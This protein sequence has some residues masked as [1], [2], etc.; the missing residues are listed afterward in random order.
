MYVGRKWTEN[1]ELHLGAS[2]GKHVTDM[3]GETLLLPLVPIAYSAA[4]TCNKVTDNIWWIIIS[5][6]FYNLPS[7]HWVPQHPGQLHKLGPINKAETTGILGLLR[8]AQHYAIHQHSR[9][10]VVSWERWQS[11]VQCTDLQRHQGTLPW[12][13]FQIHSH[14]LVLCKDSKTLLFIACKR[15]TNFSQWHF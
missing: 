8:Q 7:K 10:S 1:S 2:R 13:T 15:K 5:D 12:K 11:N 6:I 9:S 4:S 14:V 3:S